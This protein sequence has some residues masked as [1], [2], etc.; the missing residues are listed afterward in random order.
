MVAEALAI[1]ADPGDL[2]NLRSSFPPGRW[3]GPWMQFPVLT[4]PLGACAQYCRDLTETVTMGMT[5][6][7]TLIRQSEIKSSSCINK[8]QTCI[9][10]HF[11]L[12]PMISLIH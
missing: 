11:S 6:G 10:I 5:T 1:N 2:S 7:Y 4:A 9:M 8:S 3:I 12:K